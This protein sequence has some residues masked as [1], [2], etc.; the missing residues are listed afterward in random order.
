MLQFRKKRK[1]L[2]ITGVEPSEISHSFCV[3]LH[4]NAENE[5]FL[6]PIRLKPSREIQ[7]CRVAVCVESKQ[8][9]LCRSPIPTTLSKRNP[10][11]H[12][13]DVLFYSRF[14]F[15]FSFSTRKQLLCVRLHSKSGFDKSPA[16]R[17]ASHVIK[18]LLKGVCARHFSNGYFLSNFPR[19][20]LFAFVLLKKYKFRII[21]NDSVKEMQIRPAVGTAHA[22]TCCCAICARRVSTMPCQ[23]LHKHNV[24]SVR[25][26]PA[27]LRRSFCA[28]TPLMRTVHAAVV[29]R[30][31]FLVTIFFIW[32]R[33]SKAAGV[34]NAVKHSN[35]RFHF[36]RVFGFVTFTD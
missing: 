21:E 16:H 35:F 31:N 19:F 33:G 23:C 30:V 27:R 25:C 5:I 26:K 36:F 13:A 8:I 28:R 22:I 10:I 14:R 9:D 1:C 12:S 15:C 29:V 2:H 34:A 4:F 18:Q 20:V 11:L 3:H 17:K 6:T 32:I 24:S 7:V